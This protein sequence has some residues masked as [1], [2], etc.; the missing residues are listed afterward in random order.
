MFNLA[1]PTELP[2][3]DTKIL[4]PRNTYASP[5]QW[6]EK[7]ETLAKPFIDNFD[8]YT[9]TPAGAAL[10]A[11]VRNCNDLKLENVYP[12]SYRKR[13]GRHLRL[14]FIYPSFVVP[15]A[16]VTGTGSRR[17]WKARPARWCRAPHPVMV[18]H[19]TLHNCQP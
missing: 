9:D 3:V 2:G 16:R 1:I 4:Y 12:V 17:E 19:D 14:P 13:N 11:V 8:K 6:Q 10:V 15:C 18:I 5:E 7:A